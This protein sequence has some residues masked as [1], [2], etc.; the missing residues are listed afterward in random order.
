MVAHRERRKNPRSTT[1]LTL[2]LLFVTAKNLQCIIT[3]N[4]HNLLHEFKG[5]TNYSCRF[6]DM[7]NSL[8]YCV[9][10]HRIT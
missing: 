10:P 7:L 4:L 9:P 8:L 1:S 5:I 2:V 3:Y 6:P